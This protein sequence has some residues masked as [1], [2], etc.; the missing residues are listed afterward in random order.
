MLVEP[1][2][3]LMSSAIRYCRH[4]VN[5]RVRPNDRLYLANVLNGFMNHEPVTI[6]I[7]V[8][9]VLE[10]DLRWRNRHNTLAMAIQCVE[11]MDKIEQ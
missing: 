4:L 3:T 2:E 5:Y 11:H 7:Y 6:Y 8:T 9:N 1:N 10:R